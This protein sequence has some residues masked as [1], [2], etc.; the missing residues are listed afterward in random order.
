MYTKL[1]RTSRL[2]LCLLF[3]AWSTFSTIFF[4]IPI[5]N[6]GI[7]LPAI[8]GV[9]FLLFTRSFFAEQPLFDLHSMNKLKRMVTLI[10]ALLFSTALSL[11]LKGSQTYLLDNSAFTKGIVYIGTIFTFFCIILVLISIL[12]KIEVRLEWK[13]ISKWN[14]V[15]YAIP[16]IIIW[17]LYWIA[18]Y[19][20]AMTPDSLNQWEQTHTYEFNDWH[21]VVYTWLIMLIVQI[22]HAPAIVSFVQF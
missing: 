15:Y 19:P 4:F 14:L 2:L 11:S 21:P 6:A 10:F 17:L 9:V 12:L 1:N 16:S 3:A 7:V 22:W 8:L 5:K 13:P 18:F 20:A